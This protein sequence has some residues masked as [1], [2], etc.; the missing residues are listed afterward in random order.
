MLGITEVLQHSPD[1]APHKNA[2]PGFSVRYYEKENRNL[3]VNVAYIENV[4]HQQKT[5]V[6]LN[7]VC[8]IFWTD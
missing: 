6:A 8:D 1:M 5:S 4:T 3:Y 2:M 7:I